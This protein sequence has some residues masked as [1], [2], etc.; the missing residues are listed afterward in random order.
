MRGTQIL[1]RL[2]SRF[3]EEQRKRR[4]ER[5]CIIDK[6]GQGHFQDQARQLTSPA[7][8]RAILRDPRV[9]II[10]DLPTVKRAAQAHRF[11][12]GPR[13]HIGDPL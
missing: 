9:R 4:G 13:G 5:S 6:H 3:P 2:Q 1:R 10:R 12:P 11:S 7:F 8:G